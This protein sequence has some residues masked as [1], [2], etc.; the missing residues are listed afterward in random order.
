MAERTVDLV[1]RA[2]DNASAAFQNLNGALQDLTGIQE[3][4]ARGAELMSSAVSGSEADMRKLTAAL[5]SGN[6]LQ[7]RDAFN[8][9]GQA[10]DRMGAKLREQQA[11]VLANRQAYVAL[12]GQL[13]NARTALRRMN[14]AIGPRSEQEIAR[15]EATE[16]AIRELEKQSRQA[17]T[18]LNRSQTELENTTQ[19]YNRLAAAAGVAE[20]A[21]RDLGRA[22]QQAL[23]N[24][25]LGNQDRLAQR[26][27]EN[28][29]ATVE[30]ARAARA[31]AA[32]QDR[33]RQVFTQTFPAVRRL[34]AA[35]RQ[36]A[37]AYNRGARGANQ[38]AD[39]TERA[40][41][42]AR[43]MEGE[44]IGA[45]RAFAAF[46]G[47][48]R[49][50]LSLMQRLRGEV[51]SLTAAF[52]G[53]YGVFEQG[54]Q[55]VQAFQALEAATNRL[56]AAVGGNVAVARRELGFLRT[57]AERLGFSFETLATNYSS[58]L[59]SGQQAGLG[60]D[61]VR[62][63]FISVTEASRVLGLNNERVGRVFT[64][65]T[66]IAG[67]GTVQMEELRQQL[68]DNLPGAV[69]ILAEALGYGEDQLDQ[70]YDAVENG[71]IGAEEG[72]L[73]LAQGLNET[74]GDQLDASLESVNAQ[75]GRLQNN[76]FNRRLTAAN[77]GFIGGLESLLD[78][79]NGFLSSE[80]GIAFFEGLGAAA[81]RFLEVLPG[82]F[83]NLDKIGF[84]IKALV[85]FKV[86]QLVQ[87]WIAAFA[88]ML[89]SLATVG[90]G[91][92][93]FRNGM[94]AVPVAARA[95]VAGT[96]TAAGGMVALGRAA[97]AAGAAIRGVFGL[98]LGPLGFAALTALSFAAAG[99]FAE[100]VT[101]VD[102]T[103]R[104][105]NEHERII[106]R[107]RSAYTEAEEAGTDWMER[108]R[109][110]VEGLSEVQLQGAIATARSAAAEL[111]GEL[112]ESFATEV[113]TFD[114]SQFEIDGFDFNLNVENAQ[115]LER[116]VTTFDPA[117][118]D[119]R[120]F[121]TQLASLARR[122][123]TPIFDRFVAS[124]SRTA[125]EAQDA[126]RNVEELEAVL[127]VL[128][129][130]AN[131]AQVALVQGAV[132]V[133]QLGDQA[134]AEIGSL[135]AFQGA[136]EGVNGAIGQ[137]IALI[138]SMRAGL[139]L[140]A[141]I[142]SIE[143]AYEQAM[144]DADAAEAAAAALGPGSV[145]A[146]AALEEARAARAEAERLYQQA[147]T[148]VTTE[149]DVNQ[150]G[151]VGQFV[152]TD[153]AAVAAALARS[154]GEA[155]L[156]GTLPEGTYES[157]RD[158]LVPA[159]SDALG[160]AFTNLNPAQQ[161]VLTNLGRTY[162]V[163]A[164]GEGGELEGI[165]EA[166]R[167]GSEEGIAAALR[168]RPGASRADAN[169]DAAVFTSEGGREAAVRLAEQARTEQERQNEAQEEFREGLQEQIEDQQFLASL[170]GMSTADREVALALREAE[171]A[172][173]EVGLEL[174]EAEREQI[175]AAT[176]AR[177]AAEEARSGG[178]GGGADDARQRAEEEA[179]RLEAEVAR[180]QDRRA[181]LMEEIAYAQSQGDTARAEELQA[182]LEE[183]NAAL[184]EAIQRAIE[185]WEALGGDGSAAAVQ[186]L[187][188][189]QAELNRTAQ[190]TVTTGE[191]MNNM[192]AGKLT[193][194]IQRFAERVAAGE[195]AWVAFK[196]EFL[197]AIGEMLIE[198][199]VMIA[200]Q[201]LLNAL[202]GGQGLGG[203]VGG[204]LAG[205]ING[206]FHT[207]G[208]AGRT[209]TTTRTVDPAVFANAI[210][211][212]SGGIAGLRPNE[213]AAVLE[214]GEEVL[215][216]NDPRH[217]RNFGGSG[218]PTVIN[219]FDAAGFLDA[220]LA[221]NSGGDAILNY[222]RANRETFKA[223]LE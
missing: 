70:F 19:D 216:E 22:Q 63:I 220:A 147:V 133:G 122:V 166:L 116:L 106:D 221:S 81:G 31:S 135:A 35:L 18:T 49:R 121:E 192:I 29:Q 32:D 130:T 182:E 217:R 162:G 168:N 148:E 33:L 86:A 215:T 153:P 143:A 187:R 42:S 184:E 174:S 20:G 219:A 95:M 163:E 142:Q 203:G 15:I 73:A 195:N 158:E 177:V 50:A 134:E 96:T 211:Y 84:A 140:A 13:E 152:D 37:S 34:F 72:L 24:A 146:V 120:E 128:R 117:T 165:T 45:R 111:T 223:A 61:Q 218:G 51:L 189:T 193:S 212:H 151:G 8:L 99:S 98:A 102:L 23:G 179:S 101:Q 155:S 200:R 54:N 172:A 79:L 157:L 156:G 107:V 90:A 75:I 87:G 60:M 83:D 85:A 105:L 68:G 213:V 186:A 139:Q 56:E 181:F 124:L 89:P 44:V 30:N 127:A 5:E 112:L 71:A 94:L 160:E 125:R 194:A 169:V 138:P 55:I 36:G 199:G 113:G 64:A 3:K 28:A 154:R 21:V 119:V 198:I 103:N 171:N 208:I 17:S 65:L 2:R 12:A 170:E 129:G 206:L 137:L 47:D 100:T 10:V 46:Y 214:D 173:A 25:A 204:G 4:V 58:F 191:Q 183:V 26:L 175:E 150:A 78:A 88:A 131:A 149:F 126:D 52:V 202:M 7:A 164:F 207:G 53:F 108:L 57:E 205:L 188:Q 27:R 97:A 77:S 74:F 6:A 190:V 40:G 59:I 109:N 91:I 145:E 110:D 144:S 178:G 161:G 114:F 118:S 16:K 115:E 197:R 41:R 132:A 67:K 43:W 167:E 196:E 66:Q 209:P 38:F 14:D 9:I 176:R 76:L 92:T 159:M 136:V 222:V 1:L 210:R 104:A 82:I 11:D 69:G 80:D 141:N 201:A 185:F 48:S 93:A 62:D 39:A 180:L 123:N